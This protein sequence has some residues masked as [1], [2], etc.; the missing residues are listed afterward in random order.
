MPGAPARSPLLAIYLNDHLA[1]S[2]VG[3][4][5][6]RRARASNEGTELGRTLAEVGAEIE[7]DQA[8]LRRLMAQLDIAESK[9]K[10]AGAW[11]AEKLGR[12]KL[13]GQLRGYSPLS[14][15]VELE[16]LVTGVTG[17]MLLW[18]AMERTFGSSLPGFDFAALA[19]RADSQ[20]QRLEPHRLDA[21]EQAFSAHS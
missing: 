19:E 8:I 5:L 1:G 11:L 2:M 15:V 16:G 18:R 9:V 7:A 14:R 4:G 3:I 20:R 17:K 6:A 10:P 21:A 13:N 12:L